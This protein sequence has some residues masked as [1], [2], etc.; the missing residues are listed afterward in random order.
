MLKI[1]FYSN[2]YSVDEIIEAY[3][4]GNIDNFK[5]D[6]DFLRFLISFATEGQLEGPDAAY[7][8]LYAKLEGSLNIML[9]DSYDYLGKKLYQLYE[10]CGKDKMKFILL[11]RLIGMYSI[12][13]ILKKEL[14][15]RN[16]E[17]SN[18]V[19][20]ID[21]DIILSTG[22]KPNLNPQKKFCLFDLRCEER[23]EYEYELNRSLIHRINE[24]IK[25]NNDKFELLP[26]IPSYIE[27]ERIKREAKLAK[28]VPDELEIPF[29]NLYYGYANISAGLINIRTI[30]W[31]D[32]TGID[33]FS[34]HIFRSIPDGE[35]CLLDDN[36]TIHIPEQILNSN[37]IEITPLSPIRNV[38]IANVP[39]IIIDAI[40][41]LEED[42]V[43]NENS[44]LD[45]RSFLESIEQSIIKVKDLN[46]IERI[47]KAAYEIAYGPIFRSESTGE[48]RT[49]GPLKQ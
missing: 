45:L 32:Y 24:S 22:I 1:D 17:L 25:K 8:S 20:I 7:Y 10:L 6:Y 35:Q 4:E 48:E 34:Y 40:K 41:K 44:I 14:L 2:S 39:T 38:N 13:T 33:M 30:A 9:L 5:G 43:I 21:E 28:R 46:K 15:D 26:E 3:T 49:G 42:P 19:P 23:E 29:N 16:F 47:V 18:P 11:T 31:F 12:Y 27:K 36:A 37:G